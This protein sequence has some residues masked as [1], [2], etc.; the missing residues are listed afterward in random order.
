MRVEKQSGRKQCRN[1]HR[2]KK[3]IQLKSGRAIKFQPNQMLPFSKI[4]R[5]RLEFIKLRRIFSSP[6]SLAR[7]PLHALVCSWWWIFAPIDIWWSHRLDG[8]CSSTNAGSAAHQPSKLCDII[9]FICGHCVHTAPSTW[10][11]FALAT[12]Y[13]VHWY[14]QLLHQFMYIF[15][16]LWLKCNANAK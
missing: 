9:T 14:N 4:R 11:T 10:Y 16:Y 15:F 2:Q 7:W 8:K 1:A 13:N 6:F 3:S 5:L 12:R